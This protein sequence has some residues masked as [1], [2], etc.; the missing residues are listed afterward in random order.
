ML[1]GFPAVGWAEAQQKAFIR[2]RSRRTGKRWITALVKKLAETAWHMWD[3]RNS[4][5]NEAAT[6]TASIEIN[7]LIT[8]Q[9]EEGFFHLPEATKR[10][11]RKPLQEL[12]QAPLRT[13]KNWLHNI[14]TAR[15]YVVCQMARNL[16]PPGVGIIF[17]MRLGPPGEQPARLEEIRAQQALQQTQEN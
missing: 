8:A 5:N 14:R 13:R 15:E 10:Q 4:V 11:T 17:W 16:P 2:A 1:E 12:L 3:H 6:S 9:Y 7:N